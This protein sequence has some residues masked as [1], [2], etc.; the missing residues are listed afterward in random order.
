M[1]QDTEGE[2]AAGQYYDK[3]NVTFTSL[4]DPQHTVTALYGMVNVP[5]GVWIDEE[6]KI[7]RAPEVA[8]SKG[9]DFGGLKAGQELYAQA[10]RDWILQGKKSPYVTPK[11]ELLKSLV[12]KNPERALADAHFKLAVHLHA[13]GSVEEAARNWKKAQA[14]APEN[15]NYHRQEWVFEPASSSSKWKAKF[16]K[17]GDQPYYEPADLGGS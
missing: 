11:D 3:A 1:A 17:L 10:L 5:T 4:L 12:P 2:E 15:W 16:D 7:V 8:Y 9:Y 14:L 6:G 13:Q